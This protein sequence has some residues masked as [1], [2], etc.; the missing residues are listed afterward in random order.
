MSD[1]LDRLF[2]LVDRYNE[3]DDG[4]RP[5]C[6][7]E[8]WRSLGTEKAVLV[9]DMSGFSL[10]TRIHGIVY[11]MA[12]VRRMQRTTK[13]LV[14]RLGGHVVKYEADNMYAVFEDPPAAVAAADA[15]HAAFLAERI[16]PGSK[17][18]IRTSIGIACGR[19]LLIPGRDLFGD[20][21][22]VACKLGEDLAEAEE[23]LLADDAYRRLGPDRQ[24]GF[25]SVTFTV[26]GLELPAWRS[27]AVKA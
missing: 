19:L 1:G 6:E 14:E 20:C 5:A 27:T 25:E 17:H 7:E 22:N 13:P 4:S 10:T 3:S 9:L 24:A 11:Y 15:I 23:T 2:G 16:P 21:V 12:M 26:S 8:I 18:R